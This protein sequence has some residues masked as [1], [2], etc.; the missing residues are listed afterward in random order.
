MLY[1]KPIGNVLTDLCGKEATKTVK[2]FEKAFSAATDI[3]DV[4]R[5]LV[6]ER[7]AYSFHCVVAPS[8][9]IRQAP[10]HPLQHVNCVRSCQGVKCHDARR[11]VRATGARYPAPGLHS[12]QTTRLWSTDALAFQSI[13]DMSRRTA[14]LGQDIQKVGSLALDL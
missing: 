3:L 14:Y 6:P 11:A 13:A 4:R 12:R 7:L 5:L 9:S 10:S 8:P 2:R 1:L